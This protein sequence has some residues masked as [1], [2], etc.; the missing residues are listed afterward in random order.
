MKRREFIKSVSAGAAIFGLPG[1][2][3]AGKRS[4]GP[5]IL[6][7]TSEDN[8]IHWVGCYGAPFAETPNIDKFAT[9]SFQ[10]THCFANAPVCGP[11]RSGW[12][13]GIHPMS[14]GTVHM[15]SRYEIPHDKI[16]YYPDFIREAGYYTSNHRK[17]DYNIAGRPD[18]DCWD[19]KDKYAWRNR[20]NG[21]PFFAVINLNES[22]ESRSHGD[23]DNTI[24]S[25]EDV[26]LHKYHPDLPTIRKNYAKYHDAV[27]R[28]DSDLG[29]ILKE[30]ENDGLA[31]DTIVI[32]CSDHGG[33][34][35]RSKRFLLDTGIHTPLL[36]RIPE[37]YR[38][39]WPADKPG[40]KVDRLVSFID[41]PK[42]W[43]SLTGSKIPG[44]MQ[45]KIFLGPKTEPEREYHFAYIG[46]VDGRETNVR[47]ARDKRY[48]YI[49][50]YT[51]FVPR[52]QF[53]D[54][55]WKQRAVVAWK[56][57]FDA[58]KTNPTQSRFFLP[59]KS[60][61]EL[62]DSEKDPENINNLV[63]D[64]AQKNRVEKMRAALRN[65]QIKVRDTGLMPESEML[66]LAKK[67]GTTIFEMAQNPDTYNVKLYLD[68]ADEATSGDAKVLPKLIKWLEHD[69]MIVRY[70]AALGC[71]N[72][73]K[74]AALA[75]EAL[76]KHLGD[77]SHEVRAFSAM[78]LVRI[79]EKERSIETLKRL[80]KQHSYATMSV[81]NI[82]DWLGE[83]GK[84]LV[85]YVG[86]C[87]SKTPLKE[88]EKRLI[89]HLTSG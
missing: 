52:G 29:E 21:Q 1:C 45:G 88:H 6:W 24:H 70:W 37:K 40:S 4:D 72:L 83:D 28:M 22:H 84:P 15:R 38:H 80:L 25:P 64:P 33:V 51:P 5:N 53:Q 39:L 55:L 65:W 19:S 32:H 12:I 14:M 34:L 78:A 86:G 11:S 60:N 16:R 89:K 42:T 50:R 74:D 77:K 62:Y 20:R 47:A 81:L 68:V 18:R 63:N 3:T 41:M 44:Y 79:G 59:Q 31:E 30:L 66:R 76:I 82:I 69:D 36:I 75:K 10:Y 87:G 9:E 13:T 43:L 73:G 56:E 27:K 23:I 26:Q 35:A 57:H 58:G 49:K 17:T 48:L 7:I 46:R 61:E 71:V 8:N 2:A 54:Y 67:H 85:P